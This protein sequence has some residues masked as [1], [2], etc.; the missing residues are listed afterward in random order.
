[1]E[2]WRNEREAQDVL[3]AELQSKAA[4]LEREL[5]AEQEE[6]RTMGEELCRIREESRKEQLTL[7][8]AIEHHTGLEADAYAEAAS[9][10][11]ALEAAAEKSM[12]LESTTQLRQQEVAGL[13]LSNQI[14]FP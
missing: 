14:E 6:G 4:S 2:T 7:Q 8:E 9:L 11:V 10:K 3:A 5:S 13:L 1:M 12:L